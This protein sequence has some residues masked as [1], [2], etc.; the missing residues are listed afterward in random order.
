MDD[1]SYSFLRGFPRKKLSSGLCMRILPVLSVLALLLV[2]VRERFV[3]IGVPMLLPKDDD[4]SEASPLLECRRIFL[5]LLIF[6]FRSSTST[7]ERLCVHFIKVVWV[8][9][10]SRTYDMSIAV[11]DLIL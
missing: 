8:F 2:C 5:V 11:N 6:S 10:D 9:F 4:E 7:H 3:C 1:W